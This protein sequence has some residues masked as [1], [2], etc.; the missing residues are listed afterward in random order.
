MIVFQRSSRIL[1]ST[2][3]GEFDVVDVVGVVGEKE[4]QGLGE[5]GVEQRLLRRCS[6]WWST[7]NGSG[8]ASN[9]R[10]ARGAGRV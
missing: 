9:Q 4:V 2:G 8:K 5:E 3:D 7:G 10:G 1:I 6:G